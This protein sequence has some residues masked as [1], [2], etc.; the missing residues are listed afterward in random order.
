MRSLRERVRKA[1]E[2]GGNKEGESERERE[3]GVT[4]ATK[5]WRHQVSRCVG[6]FNLRAANTTH[7]FRPLIAH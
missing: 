7:L 5:T 6:F 2:F 4:V 1:S 3:M